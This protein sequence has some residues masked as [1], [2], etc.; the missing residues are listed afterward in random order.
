MTFPI[1][2]TSLVVI[3]AG[4]ALVWDVL[5]PA[6]AVLGAVVALLLVG[7]IT[8][9][10]AFG[11]F[12]NPAPV[13]VAALYIVAR[14][15]EQTGALQPLVGRALGGRAD[16]RSTLAKLLFPTAGAS[17]ILNN[18]PIVAMLAPQVAEWAHRWG[19]P[20][21]WYLMPLS[22]AAIV[23]GTITLVGTSTNVVVSGLLEDAGLAPLGMFELSALGLPLALIGVLALVLIAP[24]VLPDR[25][26]TRRELE[27]RVREFVFQM[28][29][30]PEG[31]LDGVTVEE[32]GLR[33]LHGVFLA[34]IE[35]KGEI[36]GPA[37]PD[38]RLLG[39]DRLV[40]VGRADDVM[41]LQRIA[42]LKSAEHKH[43]IGLG[44]PGHTFFEA[45]VSGT[46]DLAGRTLK[47]VGFRGR[48]QAVV[49]A[50]HRAGERIHAKLGG[51]RIRHGDTLLLL[52]DEGFGGRWRDRSDFLL[53]SHLGGSPPAGT[54]M[55]IYAVG[56]TLAMVAATA[57]GLMPI[58]NAALLAAI[59]MVAGRV[60]TPAEARRAVD[61]DVI[62]LIAA[63]FGLGAA[64][65]ASGIADAL[66]GGIVAVSGTAGPVGTLL[67]VAVVTM[68]LT[69]LITNNATAVLVFPI[70]ISTAAAA[71]LNPRPFAVTVAIAASSSFLSP[72]GYQTNTM[73][74][75]PGGYR[76]LDY[77]RLGLPMTAL[78]LLL[79][80]LIVPVVWPL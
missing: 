24:L 46:S 75:G 2:F 19:K 51:V 29:V 53:V 40:F 30:E 67:A 41:D 5:S 77:M 23:G 61:L 56:V 15:V 73:V 52:A 10:E 22:F 71:G 62:V 43:A 35:R 25:R 12:S 76:P 11:G 74:Y 57:S 54:R 34:E 72:I 65:R 66:G 69:E 6:V 8:P 48:Y 20:P 33:Q 7:I 38:T 49:I 45:V 80:G 42:G 36:L 79:I 39:A 44:E 4:A 16:S 18:T 55:A 21:S 70:A 50:I 63:A 17:S 78:A 9:A 32:G 68:M 3:L 64:I 13:T 27:D 47:E 37:R 26:G 58:L 1:L 59:L 60:L 14:A 31:A 28:E